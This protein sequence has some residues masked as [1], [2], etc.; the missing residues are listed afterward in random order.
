MTLTLSNFCYFY[1]ELLLTGLE[2]YDIFFI[3]VR[4]QLPCRGKK[5]LVYN[6]SKN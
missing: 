6:Y 2:K 1:I 5:G 3:L 4:D